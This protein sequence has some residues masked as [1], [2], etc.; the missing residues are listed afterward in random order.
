MRHFQTLALLVGIMLL[1]GGVTSAQSIFWL[2]F[3]A[4]QSEVVPGMEVQLLTLLNQTRREHKLPP[5]VMDESLRR[6]ARAHSLDMASRGYYG[7][8]TPEHE[9]P[10]QRVARFVVIRGRLG[11]NITINATAEEANKAL[12]ASPAHLENMLESG[13]HRVG[14][15]IA[16]AGPESKMITEDFAQ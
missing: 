3:R 5:L 1:V 13:F 9:S 7:H 16:S 10:A 8:F 12:V 14:I 2:S 11:E 4:S 15:G 6:A